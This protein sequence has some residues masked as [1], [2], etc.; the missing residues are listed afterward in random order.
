MEE[1]VERIVVELVEGGGDVAFFRL[2]SVGSM[3]TMIPA[4]AAEANK[5]VFEHF[6]V[7]VGGEDNIRELP[8]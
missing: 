3:F 8:R 6:S 2:R 4:A 5:G 7:C 1:E